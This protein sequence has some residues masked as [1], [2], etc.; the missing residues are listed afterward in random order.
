MLAEQY[1]LYR[2]LV[3]AG[4]AA[5]TS[6]SSQP[7]QSRPPPSSGSSD[8]IYRS[9]TASQGSR[10]TTP[11]HVPASDYPTTPTP[12]ARRPLAGAASRRQANPEANPFLDG[13]PGRGDAGPS[14]TAMSLKRKSGGSTNGETPR[15]PI[16]STPK[17][18]IY[19]GPVVDPNPVNPFA[20]SPLRRS[21][22]K[23]AGPRGS[24]PPTP[25]MDV[26][27][28]F[29]H[30]SSPRKLKELLQANSLQKRRERE[31][32]AAGGGPGGTHGLL[33]PSPLRSR[34]VEITPRTRARKRLMG[35]VVDDT[36]GK[37][38]PQRRRRGEARV[39]SG[40]AG[41]SSQPGDSKPALRGATSPH[42]EDTDNDEEDDGEN[43]DAFG[44]SPVRPPAG[45]TFTALLHDAAGEPGVEDRSPSKPRGKK[46]EAAAIGSGSQRMFPIF[47]R[48][49]SAATLAAREKPKDAV[50]P[51]SQ[52]TSRAATNR[53]N[54]R[55]GAGG[56]KT[57][58]SP[59]PFASPVEDT[60]MLP[61]DSPILDGDDESRPGTLRATPS[62]AESARPIKTL[63]IEQDEEDEW[64]PE[65]GP[66]RTQVTI[67][68]TRRAVRPR[69]DSDLESS[70]AESAEED[71][72]GH[73]DDAYGEVASATSAE[74][75]PLSHKGT[76]HSSAVPSSPPPAPPLLHLLSI[77]SPSRART[78][79]AQARA[80]EMRVKAI[81]DPAQAAKLRA[82]R[83]G[84][85][86]YL[87]GQGGTS[88]P[89]GAGP[90]G[91]AAGDE[92][93]EDELLERYAA[94]ASAARVPGAAASEADDGP[95]AT[96]DLGGDAYADDDWDSENE[97]WKRMSLGMDDVDETA[98]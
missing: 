44:P 34:A 58:P 91:A 59:P 94:S 6:T 37:E 51:P 82:L 27:S 21:A 49:A 77:H 53:P 33:A 46:G 90:G 56:D 79:R 11:R 19:S 80:D 32:A 7:K 5:G 22:G 2:K 17:K 93:D 35:E 55:S 50:Q 9:S 85:D 87:P 38:R 60:E 36:P 83:K 68:P 23:A 40:G 42:L 39:P 3:K 13:E 14:T 48:T 54:A 41:P 63:T 71:G 88:A 86:V 25:T 15:S 98:W 1:A 97:G 65:S 45:R 43:E 70:D 30:V 78:A 12:P 29:I 67:V 74:V 81:F 10:L 4:S 96:G 62:K 20:M 47:G 16:F 66:V 89:G 24:L 72:D 61:P 8:P 26:T 92:D 64:D 28:P 57:R 84:Q 31:E 75:P 95:E 52:S 73:G 76:T 69:R 18:P